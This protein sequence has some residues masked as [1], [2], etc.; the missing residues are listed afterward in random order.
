ME[1]ALLVGILLVAAVGLFRSFQGSLSSNEKTCSFGHG[2]SCANPC[3]TGH[4]LACNRDHSDSA[5]D[6]GENET[7]SDG[8][9]RQGHF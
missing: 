4:D 2:C 7:P 3:C 8:K 5:F 9:V 6:E 1:V